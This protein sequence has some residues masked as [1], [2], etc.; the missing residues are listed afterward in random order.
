LLYQRQ[1]MLEVLQQAP[2]LSIGPV[3]QR[4]DDP[5]RLSTPRLGDGDELPVS[6]FE[7]LFSLLAFARRAILWSR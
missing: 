2:S 7:F 6:F 5:P 4:F 3:L 1:E